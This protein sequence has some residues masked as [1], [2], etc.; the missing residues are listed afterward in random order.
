[1]LF[2]AIAFQGSEQVVFLTPTPGLAPSSN[3]Y[4]TPTPMAPTQMQFPAQPSP[5]VTGIS[6]SNHTKSS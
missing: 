2:A 5:Q 4:T 1:M 3:L 6:V